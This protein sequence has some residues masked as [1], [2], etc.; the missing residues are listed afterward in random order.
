MPGGC[1]DYSGDGRAEVLVGSDAPG[2]PTYTLLDA[3]GV[4]GV[5]VIPADGVRADGCGSHHIADFDGDLVPDRAL[6]LSN[7]VYIYS[8]ADLRDR[9]SVATGG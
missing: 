2:A 4:N 7:E 5:L 1:F 9:W 3:V 6:V 8:G